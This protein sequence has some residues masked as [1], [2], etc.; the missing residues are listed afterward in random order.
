MGYQSAGNRWRGN[1]CDDDRRSI[2]VRADGV[3]TAI[4]VVSAASGGIC[5]VVKPVECDVVFGFHVHWVAAEAYNYALWRVAA[6]PGRASVL[7]GI[8]AGRF[9]DGGGVEPAWDH[10]QNAHVQ[11]LVMIVEDT[12][13]GYLLAI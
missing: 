5:A 11:V 2:Y 3:A 9:V 13:T 6:L 10:S 8:G 1:C 7:Y 4:A 12:K